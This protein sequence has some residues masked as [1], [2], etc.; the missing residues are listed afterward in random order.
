MRKFIC[1]PMIALCLMLSG[2]GEEKNTSAEDLRG[3]HHDAP[4]ATME[5]VIRC[6]RED[7]LWEGTLRCVYHAE[8]ESEVEV[9]SPELIAGV[10]AIVS[11]EGF[12]LSYEG[13]TLNIPA[14]SL[15][16]ISP[17]QCLPQL[18][19]ALREGWLLEENRE[20]WQQTECIRLAL[21]NSLG[22]EDS[23]ISTLWLRL[24]DGV[25]LYGE[26]A[27]GEEVFFTVEFTQFTF[28]DIIS[29]QQIPQQGK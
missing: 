4:G 19:E 12:A 5:A 10:K 2:C 18:M 29:D 13:Q 24:L 20:T 26:I 11:P 27:V 8:G 21:D 14:I 1:V 7:L 17:A 3:L 16:E 6:T 28:H 25:P 15:R 22:G 23:V 9:L